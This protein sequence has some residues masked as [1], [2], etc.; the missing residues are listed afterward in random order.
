MARVIITTASSFEMIAFSNPISFP[1]LSAAPCLSQTEKSF[2]PFAPGLS[3]GRDEARALS[4]ENKVGFVVLG[5]IPSAAA[6]S[7]MA[8]S[9]C[10]LCSSSIATCIWRSADLEIEV[11]SFSMSVTVGRPRIYC[12]ACRRPSYTALIFVTLGMGCPSH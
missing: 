9:N 11:L 6:A 10:D 12:D 2:G 3:A 8:E 5:N 7:V 4:F 1:F